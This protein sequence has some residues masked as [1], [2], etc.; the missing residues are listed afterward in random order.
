MTEA[1]YP[2][3]D[4]RRP[5]L[6]ALVG[7]LAEKMS[8]PRPSTPLP[9]VAPAPALNLGSPSPAAG[10]REAKEAAWESG[11]D[12]VVGWAS[13]V[14]PA[15]PRGPV[16]LEHQHQHQH[17]HQQQLEER[18]LASSVSSLSSSVDGG[19]EAGLRFPPYRPVCS[20]QAH[21]LPLTT[22]AFN[23]AGDRLV[24]SS[25]DQTCKVR[26]WNGGGGG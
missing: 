9:F 26:G 22:C 17:Q 1:R 25:Y 3:S 5:Q 12:A 11:A 10:P 14:Q 16:L 8:T 4:R 18:D 20:I 2:L 21:A 7:R 15:Y 23:K 6:R 13:P 24:T 19:G